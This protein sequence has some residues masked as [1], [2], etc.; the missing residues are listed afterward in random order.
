MLEIRHKLLDLV[1]RDFN[2]DGHQYQISGGSRP[3]ERFH[4]IVYQAKLPILV[5]GTAAV[6][7]A[8]P[9]KWM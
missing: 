1:F 8:V 5:P 9:F 2:I 3:L 4:L 6:C 7:S